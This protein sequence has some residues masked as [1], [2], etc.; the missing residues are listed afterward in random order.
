MTA[1]AI[2]DTLGTITGDRPTVLPYVTT[3]RPPD[4][5]SQERRT[6]AAPAH[7]TVQKMIGVMTVLHNHLDKLRARLD[8]SRQAEIDECLEDLS[9]ANLAVGR[10]RK[11]LENVSLARGAAA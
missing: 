8:A 9:A 6:A 2:A 5:D 7:A 10:I 11:T 3:E 1:D 4:M